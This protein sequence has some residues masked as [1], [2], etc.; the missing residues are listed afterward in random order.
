MQV[1]QPP[2]K[3]SIFKIFFRAVVLVLCIAFFTIAILPPL[4]SSSWGKEKLVSFVNQSIPGKVKVDHLSLSWFGPQNIKGATLSDPQNDTV[5]SLESAQIDSSLLNLA[6]NPMAVRAFEFKNLNTKIVGDDQGNTNLMRSLDKNCCVAQDNPTMSS[7]SIALKNTQGRLNLSPET[8]KFSLELN[9]ETEQNSLKGNFVVDAEMSGIDLQ[10]ALNMKKDFTTLLQERPDATFKINA[11]IANFPVKLLDQLIAVRS[12]KTAGLITEVF[13]DELNFKINQNAA[14]KGISFN[15][16]A[17]SS[18]LNANAEILLN[19]EI[20]LVNP[21]SI[22]LKI[23]PRVAQKLAEMAKTPLAWRLA[24]PTMATLRITDL[25]LPLESMRANSFDPKEVGLIGTLELAQANLVSANNTDTL[26]LQSLHADI[27]TRSQEPDATIKVSSQASH[28]NGQPTKINFDLTIPK[29][30]LKKEFS[31]LSFGDLSI[32][33]NIENAPLSIVEKFSAI[34][35]TTIAGPFA[36]L[37]FSLQTNQDG[38]TQASVQ[39]KSERLEIPQ[40][41]FLVDENLV[42]EKPAQIVLKLNQN[43]INY[44]FENLGPQ[45]QGPASAQLTVNTFSLP[46]SNFSNALTKL[47]KSGL[48]A[49]LKV[50]TMRFANVPKLG[51]I[52]LNDLNIKMVG[53]QKHRPEVVA[54]FNLQPDGPSRLAE[55]MGKKTSFKTAATLGVGLNGKLSANIFNI[56]ILSELARIELSGELHDGQRLVLNSPT[57]FSYTFTEAGLQSMGISGDSYAFKHGTPMEMTID[58]SHIPMSFDDLSLLRLS[59]K[60]K[61]NDFQL[62]KKANDNHSLAVIDNLHADWSIDGA[63]K[64]IAVDFSG[65]TRLGENRASGKINGALYIDK[66]ISNGAFNIADATMR[67]HANASKLP[68][69]LLSALSGQKYLVPILGNALDLSI[70]ANASLVQAENGILSVDINSENLTGGFGLSLGDVIQLSNN[71]RAEFTLK[72]TPQGYAALRHRLNDNGGD[73]TLAEPTTAT[74]TFRSLQ[75]P[76]SQPLQ[77]S[78]EGDFVIGRLVGMDVQSNDAIALNSIQGHISS[79]NLMENIDFNMNASGNSGESSAAWNM[80]GSITNGFTSDGSINRDGL[81]MNFN[82]T[83][84]SLPIP[85]LCQFACVDPKLKQKIEIVLGPRINANI[86]AQLQHMNGPVYI[87]VNG[88]NGKFTLDAIVDQGIMTLNQN[89]TA[90]L[91][92]TPQLGEYVLKDLIPVLS[93]MLSADHPISLTIGKEGFALPL[94]SPS[95]NN[96]TISN[97]VLNMGKVHFS[98]ESQIAK[99]LN[100]MTPTTSSQLV[101]LTPAYFSLNQGFLQLARVDMFISDRYPL[102]AWGDADIAKDRVNMVIA[103]SGSAISKA[104]NVPK[105]SNSYFLQLPLSGRLSNPSID[106]AKAVGRIS[107]L[108]AQSQGGP[109][110]LVIGTFLDIATGG[111]TEGAIPPATTNPLPWSNLIEDGDASSQSTFDQ[112]SGSAEK[113]I[114]QPINEIQKGAT[115]IFKKLF[116]K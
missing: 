4:I 57:M 70:E 59:G 28:N 36:D 66:W 92:V 9:G 116:G 104:F 67:L 41:N 50:T 77:S 99:V 35:M 51:S 97:A 6:F 12:P 88:S 7:L 81:S 39:L 75:F 24:S 26:T 55:L 40:L 115:S 111:L 13:G 82:A 64:Q 60:L 34:P 61:I 33:G 52:S 44:F 63:T 79:N 49:H 74:L 37:L 54:S 42:L 56:Q 114:L 110:G 103:L 46:I 2:K 8:R 23:A 5:L 31:T 106:K 98:G 68:T 38:K 80:L 72:L 71:R 45:L 113:K 27:E 17:D 1:S 105:I 93:G 62:Q 32:K 100:L 22:E 20:T 101:W 85:L 108:V 18:T 95:I 109:Q 53:N 19:N 107:A 112:N 29:E 14:A 10:D 16:Q 78:L 87:D 47:F 83:I 91:T 89:L 48:D 30:A 69:E 94:R 15:L 73:F 43:L 21:A 65:I 102:A 84:E 96:I 58:S 11:D 76:R 25:K 3:N 90:Q 86:K